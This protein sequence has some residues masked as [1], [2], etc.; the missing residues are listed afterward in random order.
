MIEMGTHHLKYRFT[1]RNLVHHEKVKKSERS[2]NL[3]M[4]SSL[5]RM[6][7][8]QSSKEDLQQ[9]PPKTEDMENEAKE[10]FLIEKDIKDIEDFKISPKNQ[11]NDSK[12]VFLED[13]V[14][15]IKFGNTT[16]GHSQDFIPKERKKPKDF[17][18]FNIRPLPNKNG[19]GRKKIHALHHREIYDKQIIKKPSFQKRLLE[20]EDLI[21]KLNKLKKPER[22]TLWA[23]GR[24]MQHSVIIKRTTNKL[25]NFHK[26]K[27]T[28]LKKVL[29]NLSI[30]I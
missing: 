6:E 13:Q 12:R 23:P 15:P 17:G 9:K 5:G 3:R 14:Q 10:M 24:D 28:I 26:E 27:N 30:N 29:I 16:F 21:K 18:K 2:S 8:R 1:K 7:H 19:G 25:Y 4:S 11:A 22:N 20:E